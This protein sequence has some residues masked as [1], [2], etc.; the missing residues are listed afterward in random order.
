VPTQ[1]GGGSSITI[2]GHTVVLLDT[3]P[4]ADPDH[5]QVEVDGQV[6]SVAEGD[7]F[8]QGEFELVSITG[9]CATFL[10]GDEQFTLCATSP[11]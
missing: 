10:F 5:A 6:Y 3:F 2:G 7:T 4:A 1:P 9:D 11:K 8:A